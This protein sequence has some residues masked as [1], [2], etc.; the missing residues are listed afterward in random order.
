MKYEDARHL[1]QNGDIVSVLRLKTKASLLS[2]V[3]TAWSRSPIYHTGILVWMSTEGSSEKRLFIVEAFDAT[4]RITP[5]S[6]YNKNELR[7]LAIPAHVKFDL[8]APS[9]LGRIGTAKYSYLK[10]FQSGIRQYL[11]LPYVSVDTG[12]FCSELAAKSWKQ[13]GLAIQDTNV[14]PAMLEKLLIEQHGVKYRC[15]I[16]P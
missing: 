8:F 12:E 7:V 1:I 16:E 14:D 6:V 15:I 9:L 11:S 4:R 10:A 3:I 2:H 5:L 13:G